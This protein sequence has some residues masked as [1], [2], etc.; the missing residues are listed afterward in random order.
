MPIHPTLA[1]ELAKSKRLLKFFN[2]LP[3][4]TRNWID[5]S[6]REVKKE[7]TRQRRAQYAAEYL[8]ETME[9]ELDPPPMIQSAFARNARARQGWELM[10]QSLRRQY[11]IAILRSR[12]P[13]TRAANLAHTLIEAAQ[14]A[15][16][17]A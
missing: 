3:D 16:Q 10:P 1:R 2:S 14:Y 6:I 5:H 7:E 15:D 12:F 4:S 9:A 8:M 13:D 11:L 17:H